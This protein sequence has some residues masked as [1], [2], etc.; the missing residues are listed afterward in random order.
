VIRINIFFIIMLSNI[1]DMIYPQGSGISCQLCI[2]L[3]VSELK[4][5]LQNQGGMSGV[6]EDMR[7]MSPTSEG[8]NGMRRLQDEIN[9]LTK[10]NCGKQHCLPQDLDNV[11][12]YN[13]WLW[14][15]VE[16]SPS[17]VIG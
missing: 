6:G 14:L 17:I 12:S 9:T 10:K 5:L 3:F 7:R 2:F 11:L 15:L 16:V 13:N 8:G 4:R 1:N